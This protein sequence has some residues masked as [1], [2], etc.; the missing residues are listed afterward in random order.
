MSLASKLES[1]ADCETRQIHV[2]LEW[3]VENC[4][5]QI[6]QGV[7]GTVS[8]KESNVQASRHRRRVAERKPEQGSDRKDCPRGDV[9]L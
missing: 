9:G 7:R 2:E 5:V 4:G 3:R 6:E 1:N 8:T